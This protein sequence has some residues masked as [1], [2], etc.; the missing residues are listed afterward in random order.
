MTLTFHQ[1]LGGAIKEVKNPSAGV[2][3]IVTSTDF[4]S[5]GPSGASASV[6][7]TVNETG[8]VNLAEAG[9]NTDEIRVETFME[10]SPRT[11][12]SR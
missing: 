10:E 8:G 3:E 6:V 12:L 11:S 1:D 5:C 2:Y 4:T 7:A 9:V